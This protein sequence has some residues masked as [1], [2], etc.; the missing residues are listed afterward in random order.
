MSTRML[1]ILLGMSAVTYV[2][3]MLPMAV[4]SKM[5]FPRYL[6]TLLSYVPYSVLGA[7]IFPG[8]LYSTGDG[9]RL[10]ALTTGAVCAVLALCRLN[11]TIVVFAGIAVVYVLQILL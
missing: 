8:I 7:L 3:R 4:F 10:P 11:V 9:G 5:K 6:D 2:P 1:L